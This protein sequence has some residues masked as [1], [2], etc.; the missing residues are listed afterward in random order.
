MGLE[1]SPAGFAGVSSPTQCR[2][3]KLL[4]V[5]VQQALT[6]CD[7]LWSRHVQGGSKLKSSP[8]HA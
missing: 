5:S 1:T 7:L 6:V 8:E 4:P 3:S 2:C